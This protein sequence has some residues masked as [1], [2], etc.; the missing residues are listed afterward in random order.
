MMEHLIAIFQMPV[1]VDIVVVAV[2]TSLLT[3]SINAF[4]MDLN[5]LIHLKN[6]ALYLV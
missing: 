4:M 3:F 2:S 6:K 1:V 5:D